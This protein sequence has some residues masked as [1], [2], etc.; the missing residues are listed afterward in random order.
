MYN[1]YLI[2]LDMSPIDKYYG[3]GSIGK[4]LILKVSYTPL[5]NTMFVLLPITLTQARILF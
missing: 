5:T 2:R 3:L 4:V 1:T